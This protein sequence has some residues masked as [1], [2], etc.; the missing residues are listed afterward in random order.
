MQTP[1]AIYTTWAIFSRP[2]Y[3]IA[4]P[5]PACASPGPPDSQN[6]DRAQRI[7]HLHLMQDLFVFSPN[8]PTRACTVSTEN[9]IRRGV[10]TPAILKTADR[11]SYVN[12]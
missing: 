11:I 6:T 12:T 5:W 4:S 2:N 8:P 3:A 10:S 9:L 1:N 7:T